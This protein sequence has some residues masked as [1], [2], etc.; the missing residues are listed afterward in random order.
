M[1]DIL[2][3]NPAW[4]GSS[5]T[6]ILLR[7]PYGTTRQQGQDYNFIAAW[8]HACPPCCLPVLAVLVVMSFGTAY[9]QEPG[10]ATFQ[11][12]AQVI[13]DKRISQTVTAS[14]T[15]QSTSTDEILVP[16]ELAQLL[17]ENP[18]IE[19]VL[20]HKL[21]ALRARHTRPVVHP[22]KRGV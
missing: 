8:A 1:F 7:L 20:F 3:R 12:T 14:V 2:P 16:D 22:G 19:S 9:S 21:R 10:L 17:L 18:R 11:E 6:G 13:V 4:R 5:A 15:L